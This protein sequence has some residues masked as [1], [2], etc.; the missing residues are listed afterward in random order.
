MLEN[1]KTAAFREWLHQKNK[2]PRFEKDIISRLNRLDSFYSL[3]KIDLGYGDQFTL[4]EAK[5][6]IKNNQCL[7]ISTRSQVKRALL[8]YVEFLTVRQHPNA[9][10]GLTI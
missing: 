7:N 8:I 3:E 10:E 6:A 2:D 5:Q 9:N 4:D 1:M